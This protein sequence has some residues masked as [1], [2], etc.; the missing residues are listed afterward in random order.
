[1]NYY[2]DVY[3]SISP[4]IASYFQFNSKGLNI[5]FGDES[6]LELLDTK[7]FYPHIPCATITTGM[8]NDYHKSTDDFEYIN[9]EGIARIHEF[10]LKV[11]KEL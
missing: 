9:C 6:K 8:H 1:M 4:G 7:H 10:T 5:K 2:G 11:L 3:L